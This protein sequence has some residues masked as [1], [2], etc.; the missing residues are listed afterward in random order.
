MHQTILI[1]FMMLAVAYLCDYFGQFRYLK[2]FVNPPENTSLIEHLTKHKKKTKNY[3]GKA[4]SYSN[5]NRK[6]EGKK[7]GEE[8]VFRYEFPLVERHSSVYTCVLEPLTISSDVDSYGMTKSML[9]NSREGMTGLLS[10]VSDTEYRQRMNTD[11]WYFRNRTDWGVDFPA[12]AKRHRRFTRPIAMSIY[13]DLSTRGIDS[14]I[15]RVQAAL[16]FVQFIPYGIPNFDTDE[17]TYHGL[18]LPAE[19]LILGYSDCDSKSVFLGSIL[20]DLIPIEDV[21]LVDCIVRS[22]FERNNGAHMMVA[23][24]DMG[25]SGETVDWNGRRYLLLETTSPVVMGKADWHELN[26]QGIIPLN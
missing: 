4:E 22:S 12:L 10:T 18:S 8:V 7:K 24:A 3:A 6:I 23:V 16:H 5:F 21:V 13:N 26:I 2:I 11:G 15:N 14:R 9:D 20:I 19:S 25:L 17:W 1:I